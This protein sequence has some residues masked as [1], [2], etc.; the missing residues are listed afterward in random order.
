MDEGALYI[1]WL[2]VRYDHHGMGIG[3]VLVHKAFVDGSILFESQDLKEK[4]QLFTKHERVKQMIC[5]NKTD[6][7]CFA[8]TNITAADR[9]R[10]F[11]DPVFYIFTDEFI[12]DKFLKDLRNIYFK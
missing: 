2:N 10:I 1:K 3:R 9:I 12:E 7:A 5:I 4:L 6:I 8:L 11:A